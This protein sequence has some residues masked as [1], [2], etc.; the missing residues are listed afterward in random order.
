MTSLSS[1][2]E[3]HLGCSSLP[4]PLAVLLL[5]LI[6]LMLIGLPTA[7]QEDPPMNATGYNHWLEIMQ[8]D[9][10]DS[11][12]VEADNMLLVHDTMFYVV[13]WYESR[14]YMSIPNGAE[15]VYILDVHNLFNN[16]SWGQSEYVDWYYWEFEQGADRDMYA[17]VEHDSSAVF[18]QGDYDATLF[19]INDNGTSLKSNITYGE[20]TSLSITNSEIVNFTS[21]SPIFNSNSS[22]V[23]FQLSNDNGTTWIAC[24]SGETI[25]F[26]TSGNELK[27][28]AILSD[29]PVTQ[30]DISNI[31]I[32]YSYTPQS[33]IIALRSEY[34]I[35]SET[36]PLSFNM[37]KQLMYDISDVN[38]LFYHDPGFEPGSDNITWM[39]HYE[40]NP[41]MLEAFE[42]PGKEVHI[43]SATPGLLISMSLV[44]GHGDDAAG[45]N[46]YLYSIIAVIIIISLMGIYLSRK[47]SDLEG[48]D[49]KDTSSSE[50]L[51]DGEPSEDEADKDDDIEKAEVPENE[52]TEAF[53]EV[54]DDFSTQKENILKAIKKLD[55][56]LESGD[57]SK[58]VHTE[59]KANYKKEAVR[60]MKELDK[61]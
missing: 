13:P 2:C 42:K 31:T 54:N 46:Y 61:Q 39:Q 30:P 19:D 60:V 14:V 17:F 20:Y 43:G 56:D 3:D 6:F 29:N 49:L 45:P 51:E 15:V 5:S 37:Q 1:I 40:I 58:D 36:D 16:G 28:R 48:D 4:K 59:L 10:P 23:T 24:G 12:Q 47:D 34:V 18:S 11:E 35:F 26:T 7:A 52:D 8:G 50:T 9:I 22:N 44:E 53:V 27:Y 41:A 38:I 55:A 32:E 57:I 25:D 33:T 21:A